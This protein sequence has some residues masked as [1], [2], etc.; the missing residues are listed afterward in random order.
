MA[1]A[2]GTDHPTSPI[3]A[4]PQDT[5]E[6]TRRA[7]TATAPA[8]APATATKQS[9]VGRDRSLSTTTR[10]HT[11]IRTRGIIVGVNLVIM[12][13]S[14]VALWC[15]TY[16]YT[17]RPSPQREN[18]LSSAMRKS[19]LYTF[20]THLDVFIFAL[21]VSLSAV[22]A[23]GLVGALRENVAVLEAY[24]SL[25]ALT[26]LVN[27]AAAVV[28][29]LVPQ[30]A[31]NNL[32]ESSFVEFVQ[33][34]RQTEY[35]QHIIDAL[36]MSMRCCGFSEDAFRDWNLNEYFHCASGNPSRER[37]SVPFSCCRRKVLG[38]GNESSDQPAPAGRF[39]GHGVLLMDDQEAWRHVYTRSCADA[40]LAYVMDHLV[41]FVGV[42]MVLNM[43][44]LFMLITSVILQDQ[45]HTIS[46]IYEAYYKTLEEGQEEMQEAGLI[47]LP[48]KSHPD[49]NPGK[50]NDK[51]PV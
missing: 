16:S 2:P 11:E 45:I 48:E 42:G 44:L 12:L 35:F 33:G 13:L 26:I 3:A 9:G 1:K 40:A 36:Q 19:L 47:K 51:V 6:P 5:Q 4:T 14:Q 50:T 34:Y 22:A 20:F 23:C 7:E 25:L 41:V 15:A 38:S 37:C 49:K 46:A 31:R 18:L 10:L 39:C 21:S 8:T 29:T 32:R 28:G 24:Q 43:F 27:S 30:S 17:V